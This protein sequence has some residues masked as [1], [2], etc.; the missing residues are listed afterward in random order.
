MAQSD[1]ILLTILLKIQNFNCM[2]IHILKNYKTGGM[3]S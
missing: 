2:I 3:K 1:W